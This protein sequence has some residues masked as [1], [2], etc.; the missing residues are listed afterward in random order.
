MLITYARQDDP[1]FLDRADPAYWHPAYETL[2][3]DC[4][5]PLRPLGDFIEHITY[6]PII[7]G[8]EP[9]QV[10]Q[11]V[12]IVHQGQVGYAGVDLSEA[13]VVP[14]GCEWDVARCRLRKGDLVIPRS[15]VGAVAKNRLAFFWEDQPATVGSFVDLVRLKG[16]EPVYVA[17]YLKTEYGWAQIHRLINGVATPNISFDEIRGLR[18]AMVPE[19]VQSRFRRDYFAYVY[20]LHRH[21]L[22]RAEAEHRRLVEDLQEG[23]LRAAGQGA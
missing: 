17:L 5:W 15:G 19:E 6:G 22:P 20:P 23:V 18:I 7:T 2:F 3:D 13:I 11:G 4:P 1:R 8:R 10:E 12:A 21:R 9:P 16:I 14:E